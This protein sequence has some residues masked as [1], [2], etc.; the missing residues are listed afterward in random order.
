M[1]LKNYYWFFQKVLPK[2]FC[3]DVVKYAEDKFKSNYGLI[4]EVMKKDKET[5][6]NDLTN[7]EKE[8]LFK[9]R[10]SKIAWLKEPWINNEIIKWVNTANINSGWNFEITDVE[11]AQFTTYEKGDFY[12]WHADSFYEPFQNGEIRKLSVTVSLTD[13]SKYSGGEL[14]FDFRA[15]KD[16]PLFVQ[17]N[18]IKPR[19]SLVVFPSFIWHRV[20]PITKGK[21]QSL[22]LWFTGRPFK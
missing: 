5:N 16:K 17:C 7:K 22:V 4:S 9:T 20:K 21:R 10:K 14:E 13:P 3:D 15:T 8:T 19:G 12:G 1:I 6:F 18:E 2:K 11:Q